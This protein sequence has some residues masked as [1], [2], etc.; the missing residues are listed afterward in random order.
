[1]SGSQ[2]LFPLNSSFPRYPAPCLSAMLLLF[3]SPA[4]PSNHVSLFFTIYMYNVQYVDFVR[5]KKYL[6]I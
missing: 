1:M 6:R 2:A 4:S 3:F 5:K